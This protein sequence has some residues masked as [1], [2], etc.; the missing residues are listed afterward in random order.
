ME[1]TS[2]YEALTEDPIEK[3]VNNARKTDFDKI[4]ANIQPEISDINQKNLLL[5]VT[6]ASGSGKD[7]IVQALKTIKPG[8]QEAIPATNR[9]RRINEPTDKYIWIR[10]QLNSEDFDNYYESV[11]KEYQLIEHSI[12][13][14]NIYGLPSH[15]L[16]EHTESETVITIGDERGFV[17]IKNL[18]EQY[19]N[20]IN[21]TIMPDNFNQIIN[22]TQYLNNPQQRRSEAVDFFNNTMAV[23]NYFVQNSNGRDGVTQAALSIIDTINYLRS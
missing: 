12:H 14:G 5:Y 19:I 22:R 9:Q 15:S 6:G 2:N 10:P 18:M 7:T 17:T 1:F 20:C 13:N 8:F 3:I 4:Y 11:C 23:T 21:F 16:L